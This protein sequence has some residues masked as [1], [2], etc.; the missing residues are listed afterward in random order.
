MYLLVG[1]LKN[2]QNYRLSYVILSVSRYVKHCT[3]PAVIIL[4][5]PPLPLVWNPVFCLVVY[6]ATVHD[7]MPALWHEP[8]HCEGICSWASTLTQSQ[9]AQFQV[10]LVHSFQP[11]VVVGIRKVLLTIFPSYEL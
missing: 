6:K 1:V 5:T 7:K 8:R 10:Y 11:L 4:D 3:G 2:R 9:R